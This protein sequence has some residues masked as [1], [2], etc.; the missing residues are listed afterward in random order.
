M[1]VADISMPA[2]GETAVAVDTAGRA[3][4]SQ[5]DIARLAYR[6]SEMRGRRDG[7]DVEDWLAAEEELIP[8]TRIVLS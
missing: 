4:P 5:D 3:A 6:R 1:S 7:H 8:R 2:D